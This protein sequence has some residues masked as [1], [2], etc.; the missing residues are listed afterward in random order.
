[1][2]RENAIVGLKSRVVS[3]LAPL[4][5]PPERWR[6]AP[7]P[8]TRV[9]VCADCDGA[10]NVPFA[11]QRTQTCTENCNTGFKEVPLGVF[12]LAIPKRLQT[13]SVVREQ[14]LERGHE[15]RTC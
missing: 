13:R 5:P 6:P 12:A 10:D 4:A 3:R 11:P 14:R 1:M 9:R 7:P 2:R 15:A 8:C